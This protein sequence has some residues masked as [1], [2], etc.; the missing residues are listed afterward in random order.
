M[1]TIFDG[2]NE[3]ADQFLLLDDAWSG[4]PPRFGHLATLLQ[5]SQS[6]PRFGEE[7]LIDQ[8]FQRCQTA[9]QA[10]AEAQR[11]CRSSENW[12][13]A[14]CLECRDDNPSQEVVLERLLARLTDDTWWNQVPV[15]SG[16]LESQG[17]RK[18]DL[19]HREGDRFA[20]V[21]LKVNSNTP[22]YAAMQ[23]VQY[24][25]A[26]L[27]FRRFVLQEI[28]K[29]ADAVCPP[30]MQAAALDLVVLAP[31]EY[32]SRFGGSP[33]WL[34]SFEQQINAQ[35]SASKTRE[36]CEIPMSFRFESF[37]V[38][39]KWSLDLASDPSEHQQVVDALHHRQRVFPA[40]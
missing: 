5:L 22:L 16:L 38:D 29:G 17:R 14:K 13:S 37:P 9:W 31:A 36:V 12:R 2:M 34:E 10:A 1:A 7:N 15:D 18:I 20:I 40:G 28:Q 6:S 3:A 39:F 23:V 35:L 4:T 21:E 24:G 30:I 27:F 32:Y 26:Y 19:V 8:M 11:R 25:V 33:S